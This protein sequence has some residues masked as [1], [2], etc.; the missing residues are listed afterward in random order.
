MAEISRTDIIKTRKNM[1]VESRM[2]ASD[3]IYD[4]IISNDDFITADNILIYA[5]C[6]G[7]VMTDK[8]INTALLQGKAVFC[9]VSLPAF[10]LAFYR[11][12]SMNDLLPG[13]YGIRE[14]LQLDNLEL[15]DDMI[16][17]RTLC[18]V[19]GVIF[20]MS[21]NRMGYGKGYYDRFFAKHNIQKRIGIAY[22]FQI[23]QEIPAKEH[24]IKMTEVIYND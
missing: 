20:D 10:N 22:D 12:F 11:I 13:M 16:T 23:V 6:N 9:P 24:D 8:I 17:E 2:A 5:D 14:P 1:P 4:K 15:T 7:E 21:G 18:I 19:P 3:I